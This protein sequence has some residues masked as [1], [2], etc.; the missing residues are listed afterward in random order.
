[1]IAGRLAFVHWRS[2]ASRPWL[3][4]D[5][6]RQQARRG[7]IVLTDTLYVVHGPGGERRVCRPCVERCGFRRHDEGEDW[8]FL[9]T[10]DI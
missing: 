5:V 4:R 9:T 2:A 7:W 3:G 1:M 6:L 8:S 10:K